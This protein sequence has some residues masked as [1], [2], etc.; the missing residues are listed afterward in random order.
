MLVL[1][2]ISATRSGAV[3]LVI[4]TTGKL[5][6]LVGLAVTG[7][8]LR[9]SAE[10]R[11]SSSLRSMLPFMRSALVCFCSALALAGC[12]GSSGSAGAS[13]KT[14]PT[15]SAP[16][17][18]T[19][20]ATGTTDGC[21][22]GVGVVDAVTSALKSYP[23]VTIDTSGG[24]GSLDISTGLTKADV[25]TATKICEAASAIAYAGTVKNVTVTGAASVEL[26]IS[27]KGQPC[28]GEP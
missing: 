27:V 11:A 21:G 13:P 17:P 12:G 22:P 16:S 7:R 5:V 1:P 28:V 24:C 20:A 8:L 10:R 6:R 19:A 4:A 2:R 3:R 15:S 18:T 23:G 26:A 9:G 25:A 14:T